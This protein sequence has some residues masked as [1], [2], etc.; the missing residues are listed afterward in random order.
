MN[1]AIII[2]LILGIIGTGTLTIKEHKININWFCI[3]A[4]ILFI[5]QM[6]K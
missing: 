1:I 5:I 2:F 3:V 6:L 4:L